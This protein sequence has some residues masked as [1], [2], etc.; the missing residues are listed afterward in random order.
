MHHTQN[1]ANYILSQLVVWEV[2][3]PGGLT[4][5]NIKF[6]ALTW[7]L[8]EGILLVSVAINYLPRKQRRPRLTGS[9]YRTARMYSIVF[10][11]AVLLMMIDF[12]LC[13]IWVP[14]GV[15]RTYGFR[16]AAEVF[17]KTCEPGS[18]REERDLI[19]HTQTMVPARQKAG[20]GSSDCVARPHTPS[21]SLD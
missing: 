21:S 15:S 13:V 4:T 14:I 9:N 10:K 18:G 12:F 6:R 5:D 20:T 17:T 3:F 11:V 7:A 16:T 1:T 2:D 8:S 19:P